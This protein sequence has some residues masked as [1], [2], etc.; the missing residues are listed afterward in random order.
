MSEVE[1]GGRSG[2]SDPRCLPQVVGNVIFLAH[3]LVVVQFPARPTL[4]RAGS[5]LGDQVQRMRA[6]V[7]FVQEMLSR[8]AVLLGWLPKESAA[9]A[10]SGS[11]V[12]VSGQAGWASASSCGDRCIPVPRWAILGSG[13]FAGK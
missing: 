2:N 13:R 1:G 5:D 9:P 3:R 11:A 8:P 6:L 7:F 12:E 10:V 4:V